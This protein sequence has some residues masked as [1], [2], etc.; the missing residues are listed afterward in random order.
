MPQKTERT[1]TRTNDPDGMRRRLL[2]VSAE[3]FQ[4]RGF[5]AT[6]MQDIA[7]AAGVTGG[8]LYHHF[9]SKKALGLAVIRE[10]VAQAVQETWIE[11]VRTARIAVNGILSVFAGIGSELDESGAVRGCPLGNLTI[12]LSLADADFRSAVEE[13]FEAWRAAIA[14]RLRADGLASA[15]KPS[16]PE[17][18]A[19]FVVACYSGAM[20][21]AKAT[22]DS[23][24]LKDCAR[25]LARIM[26]PLRRR[27]GA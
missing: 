26:E 16:S 24:P 6:S 5:Q 3:A 15:L 14:Q 8:A 1:R 21:M 2:D 25:Q 11:P 7:Q 18:F 9:P 17:Q 27:S 13:I 20:V 4:S 10:R 22:Q 23:A 19:T 12:E